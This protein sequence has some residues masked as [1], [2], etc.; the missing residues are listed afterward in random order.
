MTIQEKEKERSRVY[1]IN[2]PER[3]KE[4]NRKYRERNRVKIRKGNRRWQLENREQNA[5]IQKNCSLKRY[6]GIT[7]AEYDNLLEKQEY[8]CAICG[9]EKTENGKSFA[10]DHSHKTGKVRGL[11]CNKC[12]I[13]LGHFNDD[14][15]LLL[16]AISYLGK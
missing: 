13:G 8:K 2:H 4:T 11:L 9:T 15:N 5:T 10:V 14:N 16:K 3:V 12:N 1:R 7:L 6:Y